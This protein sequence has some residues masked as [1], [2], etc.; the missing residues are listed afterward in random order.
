MASTPTPAW[1]PLEGQAPCSFCSCPPTYNVSGCGLHG[2][3][4]PQTHGLVCS[5]PSGGS[6]QGTFLMA[7][8]RAR[9]ASRCR[10]VDKRHGFPGDGR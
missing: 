4:V 6:T 2:C 3:H 1:K 10:C 9:A 7:P 5:G 8:Q